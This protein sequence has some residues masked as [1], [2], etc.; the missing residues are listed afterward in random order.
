MTIDT[1]N[2]RV[3]GLCIENDKILIIDEVHTG[4]KM[5]KFPGGGLEM[6]E[7]IEEGLKREFREEMGVEINVGEVFYVN[8][9]LQV[10]AFRKNE[11]LI[12]LY[13]WVKLTSTPTARFSDQVQDFLLDSQHEM[14]FR[15]VNL[16]DLQQEK[17]TFPIDEV[18][19]K[20][21]IDSYKSLKVTGIGGVFFQAQ[22]PEKLKEWYKTHLGFETDQYGAMF[23]WH[24]NTPQKQKALTQ[25]SVFSD[26]S[27]YFAP[28][29]KAF[30][31]NYR[32]ANLESLLDSL[33]QTDIHPLGEMQSYEY[34][35]FAS[36]M[37]PEGNK[38]EL[39]EPI[40]EGF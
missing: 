32:V 4:H 24:E 27:T 15:W 9:F 17:M 35:K 19:V 8:P 11:Q 36:I 33:K 25:W 1:Y 22:D 34:G 29:E 6:G 20:K 10:S 38:I 31:L 7:S 23:A 26:T 14:V 16:Q 18:V 13:Y 3:Y 39:W 40:D 5:T 37:D 30:M 2:I 12:S 21:L 28:S